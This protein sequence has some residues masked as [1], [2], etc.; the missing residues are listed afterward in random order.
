LFTF[1]VIGARGWIIIT[2]L[3]CETLRVLATLYKYSIP[4][5]PTVLDSRVH[6]MTIPIAWRT[7]GIY[8]FTCL[9]YPVLQIL[10]SKRATRGAPAL[11]LN[12]PPGMRVRA[13]CRTTWRLRAS[14]RRHEGGTETDYDR[15]H[16]IKATCH[17]ESIKCRSPLVRWLSLLN[18]QPAPINFSRETRAFSPSCSSA[19]TPFAAYEQIFA[20]SHYKGNILPGRGRRFGNRRGAGRGEVT[21]TVRTGNVIQNRNC[22][23]NL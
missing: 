9:V 21:F 13:R 17:S 8:N 7:T 19:H 11:Y 4:Y 2:Q 12:A 22:H 5:S 10:A 20:A 6:R 16:V 15:L 18:S 14:L 23:G 3:P 1:P